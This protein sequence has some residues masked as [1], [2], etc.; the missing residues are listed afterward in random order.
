[1][2][3]YAMVEQSI[4]YDRVDI[5]RYAKVKRAI[6]DKD[7]KMPPH[8]TVGYDVEHDR[9]RGFTLTEGGIVVIAKGT[10]PEVFIQPKR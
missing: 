5:G 2:N 7:V 10:Q 4:L 9:Q 3:S 8:T 6:I 1:M